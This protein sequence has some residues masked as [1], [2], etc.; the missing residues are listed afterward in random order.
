MFSIQYNIDT[1]TN[2]IKERRETISKIFAGL[3]LL[4]LLK[5]KHIKL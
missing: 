1:K 4:A 5:S 3:N 2:V